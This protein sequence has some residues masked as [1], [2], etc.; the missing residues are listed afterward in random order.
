MQPWRQGSVLHQLPLTFQV[1]WLAVWWMQV[2]TI[3]LGPVWAWP[4]RDAGPSVRVGG[5]ELPGLALH[6]A[7]PSSL[8]SLL[9][10]CSGVSGIS[11]AGFGCLCLS[12]LLALS[13]L[14]SLLGRLHAHLVCSP[15]LQVHLQ[16]WQRTYH[17]NSCP[18]L[19]VLVILW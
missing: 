4:L 5:C 9:L 6:S 3:L 7:A 16:F 2:D 12:R 14:S 1:P 18:W 11:P 8:L 17:E 10:G 19:S 15:S 13:S